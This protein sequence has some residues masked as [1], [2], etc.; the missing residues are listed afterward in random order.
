MLSLM[1]EAEGSRPTRLGECLRNEETQAFRG[2]SKPEQFPRSRTSAASAAEPFLD[3]GVAVHR[4]DPPHPR[5]ELP[6]GGEES[7]PE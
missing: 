3:F 7:A 2:N 1:F 4:F 5:E 6:V